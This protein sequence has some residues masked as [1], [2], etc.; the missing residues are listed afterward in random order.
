VQ[1]GCTNRS[2][3]SS[4]LVRRDHGT[5]PV[6]DVACLASQ[7]VTN[8]HLYRNFGLLYTKMEIILR[9][10]KAGGFAADVTELLK[11]YH[12]DFTSIKALYSAFTASVVYGRSRAVSTFCS[13]ACLFLACLDH[14][15]SSVF[16]RRTRYA[17]GRVMLPLTTTFSFINKTASYLKGKRHNPWEYKGAKLPK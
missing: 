5:W 14:K 2:P 11:T 17:V 13:T 9:R 3:P 16:I 1:A 10:F 8:A 12:R 4:V 6:P 15:T 7:K